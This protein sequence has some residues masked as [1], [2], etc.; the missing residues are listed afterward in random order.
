MS[1]LILCA[2]MFVSLA[3]SSCS[4]MEK[5]TQSNSPEGTSLECSKDGKC[6]LGKDCKTEKCDGKCDGKCDEK[7][8]DKAHKC[9]LTKKAKTEVKAEPKTEVKAE[10]VKK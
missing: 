1:R 2:L 3:L 7:K 9:H 4:S 8:G 6:P 10:E 5:D